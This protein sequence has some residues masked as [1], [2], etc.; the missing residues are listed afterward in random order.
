MS[1]N[2][3]EELKLKIKPF[4]FLHQSVYFVIKKLL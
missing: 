2:P 3:K 1:E 4:D